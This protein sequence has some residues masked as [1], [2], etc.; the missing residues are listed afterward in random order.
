MLIEKKLV[1]QVRSQPIETQ[2]SENVSNGNTQSNRSRTPLVG[3][4]SGEKVA[5]IPPKMTRPIFS[6]PQA[7]D[8]KPKKRF[9]EARKGG[10]SRS[11]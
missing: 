9:R 3:R 10:E 11:T 2:A 5:K 6:K 4:E 1:W 7:C 8:E